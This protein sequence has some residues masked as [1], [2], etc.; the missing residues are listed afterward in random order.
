MGLSTTPKSWRTVKLFCHLKQKILQMHLLLSGSKNTT[1]LKNNNFLALHPK[2]PLPRPEHP[3]FPTRHQ[4]TLLCA[5]SKSFLLIRE[6]FAAA[7]EHTENKEQCNIQ[8]FSTLP[9]P[10]LFPSMVCA[11]KLH[12]P[13]L[14]F[15]SGAFPTKNPPLFNVQLEQTASHGKP[16]V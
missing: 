12:V 16:T 11:L 1:I 13:T 6:R 5:S 9:F 14:L 15:C 10:P 2:Q 4:T 3:V 7:S 8:G